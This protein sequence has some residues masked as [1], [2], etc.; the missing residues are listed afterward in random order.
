MNLKQQSALDA[1]LDALREAAVGA[2]RADFNRANAIGILEVLVQ[3]LGPLL[4][5]PLVQDEA[6]EVVVEHTAVYQLRALAAAL[7]DLDIGLTTQIFD[8]YEH[9]ANATLPW[10]VR[11]SDAALIEALKVYQSKYELSQIAAAQKLAKDLT[12]SGFRRKGKVLTGE[13]LQRLKY[14]SDKRTK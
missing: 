9:G 1:M 5:E 6:H 12:A 8:A 14:P 2:E 11:E 7:R 10:H 4:E 13:N 3:H